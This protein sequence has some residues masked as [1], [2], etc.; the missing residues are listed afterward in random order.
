MSYPGRKIQTART[1]LFF[2]LAFPGPALADPVKIIIS[3][4]ST[5]ISPKGKA[6][7]KFK[8][9]VETSSNKELLVEVVFGGKL[10]KDREELDALKLGAVQMI[11]PSF[12]KF[13]PAGFPEF[14]VFD[15]PY[16]FK[17]LDA[18]HRVTE[19][20]IGQLLLKKLE[21]GDMKG[22]AF[23]DL[24]FHQYHSSKPIRKVSDFKGMK[25]KV[26]KSK[27][28]DAVVRTLGA[29]PYFIPRPEVNEAYRSKKIDG[30]ESPLANLYNDQSY[31]VQKYVALTGHTYHGYVVVMSLKFWNELKSSHQAL[32]ANAIKEATLFERRLSAQDTEDAL[33]AIKAGGLNEV[34]L[35]TQPEIEEFKTAFLPI[36]KQFAKDIGVD[37]IPKI[38]D[39]IG[40]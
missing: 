27:I 15:I 36:R 1:V 2:L 22:L 28:M 40:N 21:M 5:A 20:Y 10:Y 6:C 14:S 33:K 34:Y 35:P 18:V 9:L 38:Q 39:L 23:W 3:L 30:G 25:M 8:E 31:L 16:I 17:D 26:M 11:I 7:L 24:G 13:I 37:L 29:T 19:S 12:T 32:V 4:T